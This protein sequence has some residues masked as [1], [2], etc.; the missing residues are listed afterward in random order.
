V[1]GVDSSGA[2]VTLSRAEALVLY[3]WIAAN[4]GRLPVSCAGEQN[5]LWKLEG[6]LERQLPELMA[7]NYQ[8]LVAAARIEVE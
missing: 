1:T 7:P 2:V 8:E 3:E 5:V 6:Q 4:D